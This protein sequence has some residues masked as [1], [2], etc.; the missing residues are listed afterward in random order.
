MFGCPFSCSYCP[1]SRFAPVVRRHQDV[2]RELEYL[3]DLGIKELYFADRT[4]GFPRENSLSISKEMAG[5]FNFSWSCFLHP[6]L[7]SA[8]LLE[9]MHAAGCHTIN[10]GIESANLQSMKRYKRS[11]KKSEIDGII[12]KANQ[13]NMSICADFILGLEHENEQDVINTINYTLT[14]PI[15]FASFNV[16]AP[17]PGSEI[18]EK[19]L[20]NDKLSFGQDGFDTSA[21]GEI[22]GSEKISSE[23]LK[24]LR[25]K[26]IRKFYMRPSYLLRR[27]RKISSWEHFLIQF[28]EMLSLF[29]KL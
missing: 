14:L 18:R 29:K 3:S 22:L 11:V 27:L 16:A 20:K 13:L 19:A 5:K 24:K 12:A 17:L 8:T 23:R 2:L 25:A 21:S 1:T 28:N 15:D 10:I 9:M 26:A 4:F 7:Y 6:K